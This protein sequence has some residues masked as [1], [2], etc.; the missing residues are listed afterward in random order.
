MVKTL[1]NGEHVEY[2]GLG[3]VYDCPVNDE[4]LCRKLTL[5]DLNA[6]EILIYRYTKQVRAMARSLFLAGADYEDLVQEGMIGL[7]AAIKTYDPSRDVKFQ[8][9]AVRC[10]KN[11]MLSAVRFTTRAKRNNGLVFVSLNEAE[12][13]EEACSDPE[14][15]F[16]TRERWNEISEMLKVELSKL[17]NQI[18]TLYLDGLSYRDIS[19]TTSRDYKSVDNAIQRIRRKLAGHYLWRSQD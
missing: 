18:I 8:T 14:D 16:I 1:D 10:V 15:M 11:K 12:L 6:Q 13:S 4:E 2:N 3:M 7:L 17:E 5:G 19:E 9:Y